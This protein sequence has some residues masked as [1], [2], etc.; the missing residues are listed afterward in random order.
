MMEMSLQYIHVCV[1]IYLYMYVNVHV[2]CFMCQS[3]IVIKNLDVN[4]Q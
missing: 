3:L 2:H 1:Y 4:N